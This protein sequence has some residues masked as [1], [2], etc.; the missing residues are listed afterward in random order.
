VELDGKDAG[1]LPFVGEATPGKHR[2]RLSKPGY[3]DYV[4]EFS[5]DPRV[6]VPPFDVELVE[7]P[8][9]LTISAPEGAEISIDG[10]PQGEAPLPPI[11]LTPG[12]HFVA[13]S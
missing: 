11:A 5:V 12:R 4:R 13:V 10:R 7:K 3:E 6:G 1:E 2:F 8:A 9:L